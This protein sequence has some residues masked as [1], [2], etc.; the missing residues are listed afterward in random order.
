MLDALTLDTSATVKS[1]AIWL[2][3]AVPIIDDRI[4]AELKKITLV[5]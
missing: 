3:V 2:A 4:I 5:C 1:E